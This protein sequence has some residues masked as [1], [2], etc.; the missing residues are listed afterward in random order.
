MVEWHGRVDDP[1]LLLRTFRRDDLP[2]Y[3][4]LNADPEV[5]RYLGG[6]L[7]REDSDDSAAWAQALLQLGLPE[8]DTLLHYR[9]VLHIHI[10][11]ASKPP[12][13]GRGRRD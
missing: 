13:H 12:Y 8:T 11:V 2:H 1:R 9:K 7:T 6:P 3:A 4:V 10:R 5:A